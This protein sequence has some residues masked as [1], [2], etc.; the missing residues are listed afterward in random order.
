MLALLSLGWRKT[1]RAAPKVPRGRKPARAG[2]AVTEVAAPSYR[3]TALWKRLWALSTAS[4]LSV[5]CGTIVAIG[6]AV[7]V[8][9]GVTTLSDMLR[10]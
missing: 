3:R 10:R 1:A 5:L 7:G 8:S 6:L 9:W 2:I 4:A